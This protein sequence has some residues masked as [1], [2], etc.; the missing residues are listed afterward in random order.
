MARSKKD[1]SSVVSGA[2]LLTRIFTD[3]DKEMRDRGGTDED[4][5]RLTRSEGAPVIAQMAQAMVGEVESGTSESYQLTVNYD[6]TL[7]EMVEAGH[8]DYAN[9]NIT[10]DNFPIEGSGSAECEGVL[11]HLDRYASTT[12]VEAEIAKRG[13]RPA[14]IEELLAFGEAYPEV[15]REFPVVELGSSWVDSSGDRLV[16]YLWS[17]SDGRDLRLDWY[18]RDWDSYDRFLAVRK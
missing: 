9:D 5:H 13:L 17:Y 12:E 14:T 6:R 15:Q 10:A 3:L 16:A 1:V 2:G 4:W 8:Y 7:V 18:G 11:V